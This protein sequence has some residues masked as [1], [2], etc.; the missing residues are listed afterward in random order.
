M[1]GQLTY[2]EALFDEVADVDGLNGANSLTV[3]PDG[4]HLYVPGGG[5]S[6]VSTIKI[7]R[8]AGV[9]GLLTN[10]ATNSI[11]TCA[12]VEIVSSDEQFRYV[13]PTDA[14]GRY[15]IPPVPVGTYTLRALAPGFLPVLASDIFV[16]GLSPVEQDFALTQRNEPNLL[17]GRVT[18]ADPPNS[19]L[20]SVR[21]EMFVAS[22]FL[23]DTFTCADG[24]YELL[25]P[26]TEKQGGTI[27]VELRFSLGKL[28]FGN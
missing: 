24:R 14:T 20:V 28:H 16:E 1:T 18:D 7:L 3:S 15:S 6:A 22:E 5:D 26:E 11:I 17:T 23:A 19:P 10:Q 8:S 9:E 2:I 25:L 27:E 12:A 21:V 4:A 13:A